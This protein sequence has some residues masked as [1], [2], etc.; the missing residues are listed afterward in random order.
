MAAD[1]LKI[2]AALDQ[3]MAAFNAANPVTVFQPD[4]VA[5]FYNNAAM[6]TVWENTHYEPIVGKPHQEIDL[7]PA[8]SMQPAKGADGVSYESGIYQISLWY[9]RDEGAGPALSRAQL[10]RSYFKRNTLLSYSGTT[11]NVEQVPSIGP[12][13]KNADWYGRV[14]SVPYFLYS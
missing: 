3:G 8:G 10:L 9:P 12:P 1:Y 6:D 2:L 7:L 5:Y 14:V 11:V 13:R 4:G